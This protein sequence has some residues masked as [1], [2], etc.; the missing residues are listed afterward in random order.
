MRKASVG[1]GLHWELGKVHN[2]SSQQDMDKSENDSKNKPLFAALGK[3]LH[4]TVWQLW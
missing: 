4:Y 1:F 3:F 2:G